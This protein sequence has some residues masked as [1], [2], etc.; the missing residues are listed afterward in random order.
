[1]LVV[2]TFR[3][4]WQFTTSGYAISIISSYCW[5]LIGTDLITFW[6]YVLYC[7]LFG[8]KICCFRSSRNSHEIFLEVCFHSYNKALDISSKHIDDG[9]SC[10][11]ILH[12]WVYK[13]YC[14]AIANNMLD[15]C[16]PFY[17]LPVMG[18]I[19]PDKCEI[20]KTSAVNFLLNFH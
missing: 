20:Y 7:F 10:N 8:I 16:A 12:L 1:M 17:H 19:F 4:L 13:C 14:I 2:T 5:Q 6:Q 15:L 9:M 11:T 3:K 18:I